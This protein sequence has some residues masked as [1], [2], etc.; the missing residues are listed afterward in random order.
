MQEPIVSVWNTLPLHTTHPHTTHHTPMLSEL[1]PRRKQWEC[2]SSVSLCVQQIGIGNKS[3]SKEG[4]GLLRVNSRKNVEQPKKQEF[5]GKIPLLDFD[6]MRPST[7]MFD[8]SPQKP[9]KEEQTTQPNSIPSRLVKEC[10]PHTAI[11]VLSRNVKS[12]PSN[13]KQDT[14]H[15]PCSNVLSPSVSCPTFNSNESSGQ[16]VHL[17]PITTKTQCVPTMHDQ[18]NETA[19]IQSRCANPANGKNKSEANV[20]WGGS[21]EEVLASG[22]KKLQPPPKNDIQI[23]M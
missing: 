6:S 9:H 13:P 19:P 23:G 14:Q 20:H 15:T 3:K 4:E 10:T 2:T 1:P 12:I 11:P 21:L 22:P 18:Q 5:L 8:E 16:V 17:P 7:A